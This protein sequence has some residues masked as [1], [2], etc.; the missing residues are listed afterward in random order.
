[1]LTFETAI[2]TCGV[3]WSELGITEVVMPRTRALTIDR[4]GSA[5]TAP[6]AVRDAV[7]GIVEL[8]EGT[9]YDL[10][11]V[12][13]DQRGI[14]EFQRR[15]YAAT[16]QIVPG[17]TASYGEI[18]QAVGEPTA[19]REVGAALGENPFPIIVPCH[20]VI[21]ATGAL[22]GFSAPGGVTTKRR[23]LE[24]EHA[25]GFAQQSLFA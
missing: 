22:H 23:M 14:G 11:S 13:L 3:R 7:A 5:Q 21:A 15:V 19:A 1:M 9:H 4:S 8:L 17:R 6:D 12:V 20:R 25:P 18:A 24:I 2:G 10:R 16:R